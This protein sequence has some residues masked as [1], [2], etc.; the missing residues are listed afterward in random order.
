MTVTLPVLQRQILI[1]LWSVL[2]FS[3]Y[4]CS[5]AMYHHCSLSFVICLKLNCKLSEILVCVILILVSTVVTLFLAMCWDLDM[6][7]EYTLEKSGHKALVL[8]TDTS[9]S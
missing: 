1:K 9:A 2:L 4:P 3:K 8:L 7:A 5:V 6:E